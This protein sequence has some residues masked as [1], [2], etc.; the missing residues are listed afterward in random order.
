MKHFKHTNL[1]PAAILGL[2]ILLASGC[3]G[4]GGSDSDLASSDD[5]TSAASVVSR[6]IITGFGSV[7]VNEVRYRTKGTKIMVDDDDGKESDLKVGMIVTVRG[8]SLGGG[9]G[10]A[11]SIVYD[12]ESDGNLE[13]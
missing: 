7:Y 1:T 6:G 13:T 12:N 2:S 5:E 10:S 11:D 9:E 8:S 4:S 3:G